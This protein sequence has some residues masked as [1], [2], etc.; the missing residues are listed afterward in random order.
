MEVDCQQ[1]S[2]LLMSIHCTNQHDAQSPANQSEH[3]VSSTAVQQA[4][5]GTTAV[6]T[7]TLPTRG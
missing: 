3:A 4:V 2:D 5:A 7:V 6:P 1:R